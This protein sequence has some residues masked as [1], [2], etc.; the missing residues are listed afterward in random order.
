MS[1]GRN[2]TFPNITFNETIVGPLPFE[3]DWR[4]RVGVA[5]QFRRGPRGAFRVTS[6]QEFAALY[7][8]DLS[9]G[10]VL[11]RELMYQGVTDIM[12]SR[13]SAE[14]VAAEFKISLSGTI[15]GQEA[16]VGYTGNVLRFNENGQPVQTTGLA[17]DLEYVGR[18]A[19]L[20]RAA[21][22]VDVQVDSQISPK[23]EFSGLG[24]YDL[25]VED[26]LEAIKRVKVALGSGI[27]TP[28][29]QLTTISDGIVSVGDVIDS[30]T[31]FGSAGVPNAL[32]VF[33]GGVHAL[34]NNDGSELTVVK[35]GTYASAEV[36]YE[37]KEIQFEAVELRIEADS[38]LYDSSNNGA[39]LIAVNPISPSIDP[40]TALVIAN[41]AVAPGADFTVE[42]YIAAGE[43][44]VRD[45]AG[46]VSPVSTIVKGRY[47]RIVDAGTTD[48][49]DY[50]APNNTVGTV[51][52]AAVNGDEIT[53]TGTVS[54]HSTFDGP[55]G[56]FQIVRIDRQDAGNAD[57]IGNIRPG[58]L[59]Y[60]A[61]P[62]I[63]FNPTSGKPLVVYSPLYVDPTNPNRFEFVVKGHI[64]AD[65]AAKIK[66]YETTENVYVF[67]SSYR[68]INAENLGYRKDAADSLDYTFVQAQFSIPERNSL[69]DSFVIA[70]EAAIQNNFD[71][72]IYF[73]RSDGRLVAL[74]SG[75]NIELP[76]INNSN[77][78]A[79]LEGGLY[80]VPFAR[81]TAAI[82]SL[83]PLE[84]P[85]ER[86]T[87]ASQ[88]LRR[89]RDKVA[90]DTVFLGLVQEPTLGASLLPPTLEFKVAFSGV[91]SNRIRWAMRKE[92]VNETISVKAEDFLLN[93]NDISVSD[94][95]YN[96]YFNATGGQDGASTASLDL[97]SL[98]SD[99]LVRIV[100]L[101]EGSF[102]NRI[103]VSVTTQ[104][105]GQFTIF[106]VDEDSADYQSNPT[107]ETII[108]STRDVNPTT[109]LFNSSANSNL[110]RIFYLPYLS[111][112]RDLTENE[113]NKVPARLA[114]SFGRRIPALD[115]APNGRALSELPV[116]S[117]AY[118]GDS[119]LQN[120]FLSGGADAPS[121]A[122]ATA[123]A[124]R[125]A[126]QN[127]ESEDIAILVAAGVT[128]GDARYAS[129][130]EEIV[131]Q[132]NRSTP[133]TGLR[134]GIIQA[135]RNLSPNQ[136]QI[137]AASLNNSRIV[138]V[139]GH[140]SIVGIPGV[141]NT[142]ISG[143]YAGILAMSRPE[144]SPASPSEG[145]VPNGISSV[146]TPS[147]PTYLDE[148][149]KA[150]TEV[151]YYDA[152]LRMFKFLNGIS[153]TSVFADRYIGVRRMA[154][155]ILHDLY[156]GLLWV[157]SSQ[158]T[159]GLRARVA[160]S[161]DAYLQ[162]QV[163]ENR[164]GG[165]RFTICN[166]S[167]NTPQTISQGILN[168]AIFWTPIYPA[169]FIRVNV[170][171][172]ITQSLTLAV[173]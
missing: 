98:D 9:P 26:Y 127:L 30:V 59:I 133:T 103:R 163:R 146:D 84:S 149:T 17:L 49:T 24:A 62:T 23:V 6:R 128:A 165:F 85:F 113:L 120:L 5:G 108:C 104:S 65:G 145:S 18:A 10:A 69:V 74:K 102:A 168:I 167:N 125:R 114:P 14:P 38:F 164:I 115:T 86:G 41:A 35:A 100:S 159:A 29:G 129:V 123:A 169:D 76:Q 97:F 12:I 151:I 56:Q 66:L 117:R 36:V 80:R 154:D 144:V 79:F 131:G 21:G 75:I 28:S 109:G 87:R 112:Q 40:V 81:T 11:V 96:N 54:E 172:E 55:E 130:I 52:E 77:Q 48:F 137:Y 89:L 140:A 94:S 67:S 7:G 68:D 33:A 99:P 111:G 42:G 101:S 141:N 121:S 15:D 91:E 142:P 157:R 162:N 4:N 153:T 37:A 148:I 13:A 25:T 64:T 132:V 72:R 138:L 58:R 118:Q 171:R 143:V 156:R 46:P 39:I 70:K 60:S 19:E 61:D 27:A 34:A 1:T 83:N 107:T 122:S 135:P 116:Y 173:Q 53:G 92:T 105:Q 57:V 158:N 160:S 110:V 78:V 93:S 43:I 82:G 170:T 47:Y 88:I 90:V 8:E 124:L 32:H 51:F 147:T 95:T 71:H 126:V 3:A 161:C 155:Q 150:R 119:F 50:G 139:G 152:G 166:D 106:L 22:A 16:Q 2:Y 20:I 134:V 73:R 31:A 45:S 44:Q 136:A 63:A